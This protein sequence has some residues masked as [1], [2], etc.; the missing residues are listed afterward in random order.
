MVFL[1]DGYY[2]LLN[3]GSLF[4]MHAVF[5]ENGSNKILISMLPRLTTTA[6]IR[7][8]TFI[9]S[10]NMESKLLTLPGRLH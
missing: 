7:L 4:H 6:L 1:I 9:E 3:A 5:H 8:P 10:I 2:F